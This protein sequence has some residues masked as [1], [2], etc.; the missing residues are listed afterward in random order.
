[1]VPFK[2]HPYKRLYK[3]NFPTLFKTQVKTS[4]T[5]PRLVAHA[6]LR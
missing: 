1:M 5:V 4:Q 6:R 2:E 3:M